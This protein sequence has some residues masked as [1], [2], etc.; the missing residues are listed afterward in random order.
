MARCVPQHPRLG[1]SSVLKPLLSQHLLQTPPLGQAK[2]SNHSPLNPTGLWHMKRPCH[3]HT[4]AMADALRALQRHGHSRAGMNRCSC[5]LP[6][7]MRAGVRGWKRGS[8]TD[9]GRSRYENCHGGPACKTTASGTV[10]CAH[11][12]ARGGR[13]LVRWRV[14]AVKSRSSAVYTPGGE[15]KDRRLLLL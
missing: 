2:S 10:R 1:I 6:G 8:G 11:H 4:P 7:D 9:L 14:E 13:V 15:E 12:G 3:D 5:A